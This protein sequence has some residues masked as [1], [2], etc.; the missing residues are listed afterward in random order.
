MTNFEALPRCWIPISSCSIH[1][2]DMPTPTLVSHH[3]DSL[4]TMV[5]HCDLLNEYTKKIIH[6]HI[7]S[8]TLRSCYIMTLKT[9][10][11]LQGHTIYYMDDQDFVHKYLTAAEHNTEG[12]RLHYLPEKYSAQNQK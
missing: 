9:A 2:E 3:L 7:A 11:K 4:L 8:Q 6:V 5:H 10:M 12:I 1:V